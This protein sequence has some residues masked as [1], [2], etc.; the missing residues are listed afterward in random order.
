MAAKSVYEVLMLFILLSEQG[1]TH[2]G[3]ERMT[4]QMNAT[5]QW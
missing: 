5:E 1:G 4:I 2:W 3:T